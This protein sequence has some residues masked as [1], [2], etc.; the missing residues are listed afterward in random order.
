MTRPLYLIGG[1]GR[2]G[3]AL[4]PPLRHAGYDVRSLAAEAPLPPEPGSIFIDAGPAGLTGYEPPTWLNYL[5]AVQRG[6]SLIAQAEKA[7]YAAGVLLSTPWV[8]IRTG[9]PYADSKALIEDIAKAHNRHGRTF[10]VVDRVG[11]VN[12][13]V[14]VGT[15]SRFEESVRQREGELG[16][17]IAASLDAVLSRLG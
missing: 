17:R 7:S 11:M 5:G 14:P 9:D 1:D 3:R 4:T 12:P 2:V 16:E 6:L 15:G 8:Q 13:D 10:I